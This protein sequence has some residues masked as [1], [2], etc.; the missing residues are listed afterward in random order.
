ML[1]IDILCVGKLKESYLKAAEKEYLRRL[2]AFCKPEVI[3]IPDEPIP[4]NPS[5]K[6]CM[7]VLNKEGENI[8][9]KMKKD[10]CCIVLDIKGKTMDSVLFSDTIKSY[11][12]AGQSHITFVIGGSL[13]LSQGVKDRAALRLSLSPMTFTHNMTRIILLEQIYRAFSIINNRTYHK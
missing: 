12:I 4:D 9:Y 3:E 2:S 7:G 6:E 1:R 8:L 5:T 13:G 10:T 11:M